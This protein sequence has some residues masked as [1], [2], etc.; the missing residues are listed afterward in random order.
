MKCPCCSDLLFDD[1]CKP[2]LNRLVFPETAEKLMRSRYS[3]YVLEDI[4]YLIETTDVSTVKLYRRKDLEAWSK[5][6]EW[7]KLEV[8]SAK[9]GQAVDV[10]GNVEFK[11]SYKSKGEN[12]VHHEDSLFKKEGDRWFYVSGN[13][14]DSD[15]KTIKRN[16]PCSCGSGKKFKKCCGS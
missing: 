16:D 3:A 15:V 4:D 9:L 13:V 1:C 14:I 12:H 7:L 10:E 6:S 11:A 2:F 5:S 8:V